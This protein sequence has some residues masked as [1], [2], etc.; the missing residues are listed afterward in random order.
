MNPQFNGGDNI[1]NILYIFSFR[2]IYQQTVKIQ[3]AKQKYKKKIATPLV[4]VYIMY[5]SV[6]KL[7][8]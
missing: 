1:Y 5:N 8:I 6:G 3:L 4:R 2:I 7:Y